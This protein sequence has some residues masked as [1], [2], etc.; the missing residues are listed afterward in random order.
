MSR[1]VF[2]WCRQT[3]LAANGTR[4]YPNA[5][6]YV[7]QAP[8]EAVPFFPAAQNSVAPCQ[9]AGRRKAFDGEPEVVPGIRAVATHGH[10]AGHTSSLLSS[11][12]ARPLILGDL[13]HNFAVQFAKPDVAIDFAPYER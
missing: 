11:G 12:D 4:L 2:V 9:Q 3:L 1:S 10:I 13:V 6:V 5:T 7:A 8:K